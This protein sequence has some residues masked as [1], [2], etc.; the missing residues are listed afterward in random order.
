[1][2]EELYS[3]EVSEDEPGSYDLSFFELAPYS[4]VIGN[5]TGN[6]DYGSGYTWESMVRAVQE[7]RGLE[8][9]I[10]YDPESDMFAAY[11]SRKSDLKELGKIIEEL[12]ANRSLM[13]EA[14][15]RAESE[16]YLE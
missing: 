16:G 6:S 14:L 15:T 11:S 8:L 9:D 3:I 13:L 4:E 2:P 7:L 10:E 1:M 12:I 5:V